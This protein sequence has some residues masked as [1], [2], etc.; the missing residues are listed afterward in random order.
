MR[1]PCAWPC[2]APEET[3]GLGWLSTQVLGCIS[4][5]LGLPWIL[6]ID[7]TVKPLYSHQQGA[8]IGYNPQNPNVP[9][10]QCLAHNLLLLLEK[11][12]MRKKGSA[13]R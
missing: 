7:V 4:P 6:D 1:T 8:G 9:I 13:M 2:I 3:A 11:R 10:F 5:A 12:I